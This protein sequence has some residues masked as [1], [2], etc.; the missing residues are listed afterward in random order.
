[1]TFIVFNTR[2]SNTCNPNYVETHC[3]PSSVKVY[4]NR[5]SLPI[6]IFVL[7]LPIVFSYTDFGAPLYL[8]IKFLLVFAI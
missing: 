4:F 1:M 7:T 3:G 6:N 5:Q 2:K 8:L